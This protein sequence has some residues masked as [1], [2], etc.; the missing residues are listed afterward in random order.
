[1]TRQEEARELRRLAE[2]NPAGVATMAD[3]VI[4]LLTYDWDEPE[5]DRIVTREEAATAARLLS[6]H[7]GDALLDYVAEMVTVLAEEYETEL[8]DVDAMAGYAGS[9]ASIEDDLVEA[10]AH[11]VTGKGD[12]EP[13]VSE[14]AVD[15][16]VDLDRQQI[17][18]GFALWCLKEV[19][20]VEPALVA[21]Y[22]D[23]VETATGADDETRIGGALLCLRA[24]AT[25]AAHAELV[26]P[27]VETLVTVVGTAGADETA[28]TSS[29]REYA[30]QTLYALSDHA[31]G[32]LRETVPTLLDSVEA[33]EKTSTGEYLVATLE[34]VA[35]AAPSSLADAGDTV[36]RALESEPPEVKQALLHLLQ[37]VA[38]D[39]AVDLCLS[40]EQRIDLLTADHPAV[41]IQ[42]LEVLR[43]R[44]PLPRERVEPL[45]E[46]IVEADLG[47][48]D[49]R[50]V[51][52][53]ASLLRLIALD[54]P[55]VVAEYRGALEGYLDQIDDS[56]AAGILSELVTGLLIDS[57][58]G[59][60]T[61]NW[62]HPEL[63][64]NRTLHGDGLIA[65]EQK[66]EGLD[67][68][69]DPD[70][71]DDILDSQDAEPDQVAAN[72]R[73]ESLATQMQGAAV[74]AVVAQ[75]DT[76]RLEDYV[77]PLCQQ[78]DDV[79]AEVRPALLRALVIAL[80]MS[81]SV[82]DV[83]ADRLEVRLSDHDHR[84]VAGFFHFVNSMCEEHPDAVQTLATRHRQ[85]FD[86]IDGIA[87][88]AVRAFGVTALGTLALTETT[89]TDAYV[90][91]FLQFVDDENPHVRGV[92]GENLGLVSEREPEA[93]RDHVDPVGPL[94]A[95]S[96]ASARY[97]ST[98]ALAQTADD[99]PS[100][101][102]AHEPLVVDRF[103]DD[104]A[105]VRRAALEAFVPRVEADPDGAAPHL[106]AVADHLSD[107]DSTVRTNA[108]WALTQFAG[109][110]YETR[111]AAYADELIELF[112]E[113]DT[114]TVSGFA[115]GT[116]LLVLLV[117]CAKE[118]PADVGES[119]SAD[120][121]G[122]L[123]APES[124]ALDVDDLPPRNREIAVETGALL[125]EMLRVQVGPDA[126]PPDVQSR[127]EELDDVGDEDA[128]L[129]SFEL[130]PADGDGPGG[131]AG[132]SASARA[133][134]RGPD[135]A[136][137]GAEPAIDGTAL[138]AHPAATAVTDGAE[139]DIVVDDVAY[140]LDVGRLLATADEEPL[141]RRTIEGGVA[142]VAARRPAALRPHVDRLVDDVD[143]AGDAPSV[144]LLE[145]L[146][147]VAADDV[148]PFRDHVPQIAAQLTHHASEARTAAAQIFVHLA[149]RDG[150]LVAGQLDALTACIEEGGRPGR[151]A[152]VALGKL[153]RD[154]PAHL[155]DAVPTVVDA[156]DDEAT[157]PPAS[158]AVL[159]AAEEFPRSVAAELQTP[160][161][162]LESPET[163]DPDALDRCLVAL[164]RT[165]TTVP[166]ALAAQ[167][168]GVVRVLTAPY[169]ID[170]EVQRHAVRCLHL[171]AEEEPAVALERL[172][173]LAPLVHHDRPAVQREALELMERLVKLNRAAVATEVAGRLLT[174]I[175]ERDANAGL[176]AALVRDCTTGDE[177]R[178][179]EDGVAALAPYAGTIVS[180]LPDAPPDARVS[181]LVALDA[182]CAH[183][184][185]RLVAHV[186]SIA[187]EIESDDPAV[188]KAAVGVVGRLVTSR[189]EWIAEHLETV[190][191]VM[192]DAREVESLVDAMGQ[193]GG[194]RLLGALSATDPE[195]LSEHVE[196]VTSLTSVDA[197]D[198]TLQAMTLRNVAQAAPDAFD[199]ED[200][201]R[202]LDQALAADDENVS[203]YTLAALEALAADNP[204]A[205][206][207]STDRFVDSLPRL[208]ES[209]R[210]FALRVLHRLASADADAV[211]PHLD[212]L[213]QLVRTADGDHRFLAVDTFQ[214]VSHG[215]PDAVLAYLDELVPLAAAGTD[216]L[217]QSVA[218]LL[219]IVANDH[220]DRLV[221]FLD[222]L[223]D[224]LGD[225]NDTT[226]RYAGGAIESIASADPA[227][228]APHLDALVARLDTTDAGLAGAVVPTVETLLAAGAVE[229]SEEMVA[230]LA[231]PA[232]RDQVR[233]RRTECLLTIAERDATV[234]GAG[235]ET[236]RRWAA[237]EEVRTAVPAIDV[238]SRLPRRTA[239]GAR[240]HESDE[241]SAGD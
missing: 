66:P 163:V 26:T 162:A 68:V 47:A 151:T 148:A 210:R 98:N 195:P 149:D 82:A 65:I 56:M 206:A 44:R 153:A 110:G 2:E 18:D 213:Y 116:L 126:L 105:E 46:P 55:D 219:A 107:T 34:N 134:S 164:Y 39:D 174:A 218:G 79:H 64:S 91:R 9:L 96:D 119:I 178:F 109:E 145:A 6:A 139:G 92:V 190:L 160:L 202:V 237:A 204:D 49:E 166:D 165:G 184:A 15:L 60:I 214:Q 150:D 131:A 124:I 59:A 129:E 113:C 138:T 147:A 211:A 212:A 187:E 127:L 30:A 223:A 205:V 121:L 24:F 186:E 220:P 37:T 157:R 111:I 77:D 28:W 185:S 130:Q 103:T 168:P 88:P 207:P 58:S 54:D 231:T 125:C 120:V 146:A 101:V 85:L 228:V 16:L 182:I 57:P 158:L 67:D 238:L 45:L 83:V 235:T 196:F 133:G 179:D 50:L 192:D 234:A 53:A 43:E 194:M 17:G 3:R 117:E 241:R 51:R 128:R 8:A 19:A 14:R 141:D 137:S 13:L 176:A 115:T 216:R 48:A 20:L 27:A 108:V 225:S 191:T 89:D 232:R 154:E 200:A 229:P 239:P 31:A 7:D 224:W 21:P 169:D 25:D 240:A 209:P 62:D 29:H 188:R 175:Q 84:T 180:T 230:Q 72:L 222:A 86:R 236:L 52:R 95:D 140:R 38:G 40:T 99:Y 132:A 122:A 22:S 193:V 35:S 159:Q 36:E 144:E 42:M 123:L 143:S 173:E 181:L 199:A 10:L 177:D 32:D 172:D 170:A 118:R 208:P 136:E 63:D 106:E 78:F 161:P 183:D 104:V 97:H 112:A 233:Q 171:L 1:M 201:A 80:P 197:V 114:D 75:S 33:V 156:L 189:Q 74:A 135:D 226:A 69:L 4:E 94:L 203:G 61:E 90:E 93:I 5:A 152:L 155:R 76:D 102:T 215:R 12:P 11:T 198:A 221:P 23:Y 142:A 73:D 70:E 87:N 81:R 217:R 227:A 71:M 100:V 167:V 41:Q